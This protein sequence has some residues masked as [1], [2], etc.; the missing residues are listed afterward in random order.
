[1]IFAEIL[2]LLGLSGGL[3]VLIVGIT[4][5]ARKRDADERKRQQRLDQMHEDLKAA[6]KARDHAKL[7]DWL[8]VYADVMDGGVAAQVKIRRDE[9]YIEKNP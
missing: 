4:A 8:V 1:M 5:G 9:L 3:G 6:L 2:A 7:D